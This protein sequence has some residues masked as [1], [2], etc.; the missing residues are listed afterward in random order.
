[1]MVYRYDQS[2]TVLSIA[3]VLA[4]G[5]NLAALLRI[6]RH[7]ILIYDELREIRAVLKFLINLEDQSHLHRPE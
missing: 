4:F 7:L 3:L 5:A 1:M 2:V 6:R